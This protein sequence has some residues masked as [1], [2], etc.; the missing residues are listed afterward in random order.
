MSVKNPRSR[1]NP[2][3]L[4]NGALLRSNYAGKYPRLFLFL[5]CVCLLLSLGWR[6]ENDIYVRTSTYVTMLILNS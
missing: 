4:A 1:K 3:L 2:S 5:R 6:G